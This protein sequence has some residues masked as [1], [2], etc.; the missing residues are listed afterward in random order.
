MSN[1]HAVLA[2][3]KAAN[4]TLLNATIPTVF[5]D[6]GVQVELHEHHTHA[7]LPKSSDELREHAVHLRN[8]LLSTVF[9]FS[10]LVFLLVCK[11]RQHK[12]RQ[13]AIA[14]PIDYRVQKAIA[15]DTPQ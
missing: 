7:A 8:A 3:A 2:L 9:F 4:K 14:L 5:S 6:N 1:A 10:L 12:R 11:A 15:Q 13:N